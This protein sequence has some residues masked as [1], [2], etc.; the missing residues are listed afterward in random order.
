MSSAARARAPRVGGQRLR[1]LEAEQGRVGRLAGGGVLAGRLAEVGGRAFDVEHVVDDLEGEADF[2]AE[3]A[4]RRGSSP[5]RRRPSIAPATAAAPISAPVLR[6]CMSASGGGV[7]G[8][9]RRAVVRADGVE[10]DRL[11]ADHPAAPAAAAMRAIDRSLR[12]TIAGCASCRLARQQRERFREEAVAGEDRH[13][14]AEADVVRRPSAAQ[15]VVV[16]GRQVVVDQRV[17]VNQLERAR[18]RQREAQASRRLGAE[19]GVGGGQ[20][21][22]R[23]QR[24]CRRRA[25]RSASRRRRRAGSGRRRHGQ[26]QARVDRRAR[27]ASH[28]GEGVTARLV[29][30]RRHPSP[31]VG[32][33]GTARPVR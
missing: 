26:A 16:H 11:A 27:R 12:A 15:R 24:A 30:E 21:Q 1:S 33:A 25:A 22:E 19:D 2:A 29:S 18:R 8:R 6:A 13:A 28:V 23:T 3:D 31:S 7:E 9:A 4:D 20:R 17:G 5:R 14:L 32:G 10:I